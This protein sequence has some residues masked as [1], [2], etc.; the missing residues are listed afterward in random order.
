MDASGRMV[1]LIELDAL[2]TEVSLKSLE[3]GNYLFRITSGDKPVSEISI[4]RESSAE[5]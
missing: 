1:K 4:V 3:T 2:H 5:N